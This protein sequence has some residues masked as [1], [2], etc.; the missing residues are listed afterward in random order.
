MDENAWMDEMVEKR[1]SVAWWLLLTIGLASIVVMGVLAFL[2]STVHERVDGGDHPG[3]TT[4]CSSVA[5][6]GWPRDIGAVEDRMA[7]R[8]I[9]STDTSEPPYDV[10]A[11][12]RSLFAAGMAVFAVPSSLL[13]FLASD[14][15]LPAAYLHRPRSGDAQ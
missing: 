14:S 6:A 12:R 3:Y 10:C 15:L 8:G 1:R 4:V 9:L 5:V 2:P 7:A 13:L 11:N